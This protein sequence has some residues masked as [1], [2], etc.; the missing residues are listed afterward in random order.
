MRQPDLFRRNP[1]DKYD[2]DFAAG[3]AEGQKKAARDPQADSSDARKR[4]A[5]VSMQHG[6]DWMVGYDAAIGVA[7]G[8][9][10][11]RAASLGLLAPARDPDRITQNAMT[12]IRAGLAA[13][14]SLARLNAMLDDATLSMMVRAAVDAALAEEADEDEAA[15]N[16]VA[17]PSRPMPA[18]ATL[19]DSSMGSL[20]RDIDTMFPHLND[21]QKATLARAVSAVVTEAVSA[22]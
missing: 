9:P 6:S 19:P 22:A 3:F 17:F 10:S 11:A 4:Y 1:A 16:V 7:R 2:V 20:E 8:I 5:K 14:P 12:S 18:A 15:P 13:I 21:D